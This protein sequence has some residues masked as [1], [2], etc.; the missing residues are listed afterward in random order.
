MFYL[1]FRQKQIPERDKRKWLHPTQ[2]KNV[3]IGPVSL[4]WKVL[5]VPLVQDGCIS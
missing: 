3:E 1:M 5:S 2:G 4:L